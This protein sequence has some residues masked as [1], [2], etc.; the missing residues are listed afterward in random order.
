M[1]RPK[2]QMQI[3]CV[4]IQD[5]KI[6]DKHKYLATGTATYK[7]PP[8]TLRSQPHTACS[9]RWF[10]V[11]ESTVRWFVVREKHCWMAAD[12]VDKQKRIRRISWA[13]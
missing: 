8:A 11:V 2:R 1:R 13:G 5:C 9:F 3:M 4:T 12:L 6:I 7:Q 10:I